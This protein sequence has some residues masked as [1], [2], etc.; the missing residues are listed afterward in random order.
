MVSYNQTLIVASPNEL[1]KKGFVYIFNG[2]R[3]HWSQVQRIFAFD[4]NPGDYFGESMA[5]HKNR[6]VIGARGT[7]LGGGVAFVYERPANSIY[8]SRQAKLVPRDQAADQN[9]AQRVALYEDTVAVSAKNGN[10]QG[11]FTGSA[12]LFTGSAGVW[13]QQQKLVATEFENY[14]LG[15]NKEVR[16]V[17]VFMCIYMYLCL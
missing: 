6:L 17:Y 16:I 10:T 2:T 5:L 1:S 11:Y 8:W 9:F 3:R 13:S 15:L 14:A 12:Y 7:A 4:G